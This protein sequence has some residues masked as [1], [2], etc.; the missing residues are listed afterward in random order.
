METTEGL[1]GKG[2]RNGIRDVVLVVLSIL[3]AFG[4]DAWW[5]HNG[6][7]RAEHGLRW[8]GCI[9]AN[10]TRNAFLRERP[11]RTSALLDRYRQCSVSVIHDNILLMSA[12]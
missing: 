12:R 9:R 4:L 5:D 6:D 1:M 10:G 8:L 2:W 7:R 3:I 11:R